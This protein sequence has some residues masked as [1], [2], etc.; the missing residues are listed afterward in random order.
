MTSTYKIDWNCVIVCCTKKAGLISWKFSLRKFKK[1]FGILMMYEV[2]FIKKDLTLPP[3]RNS[4]MTACAFSDGFS[5]ILNRSSVPENCTKFAHQ[6]WTWQCNLCESCY[7][8]SKLLLPATVVKKK[9]HYVFQVHSFTRYPKVRVKV[10]TILS[11][12]FSIYLN[13]L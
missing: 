11:V 4:I 8:E 9:L 5:W 2:N 3:L 1:I 6:W 10:S 12:Q 13:G 7:L